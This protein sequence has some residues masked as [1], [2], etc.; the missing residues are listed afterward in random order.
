MRAAAM[1]LALMVITPPTFADTKT[2]NELLEE[3]AIAVRA[4]DAEK[5][6]SGFSSASHCLGYLSGI[7]DALQLTDS[8]LAKCFPKKVTGGQMARIFVKYGRAR[9]EQLH[10]SAGF[11]AIA[12]LV[13]AFACEPS[14]QA[15]P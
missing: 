9:P 6:E 8:A 14:I 4:A 10:R 11:V 7:W 13:D 2:A 1:V 12:S 3:C 5:L 15:P